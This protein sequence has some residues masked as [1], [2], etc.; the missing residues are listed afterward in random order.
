MELPVSVLTKNQVQVTCKALPT[1][2]TRSCD[3]AGVIVT[4]R[5]DDRCGNGHNTFSITTDWLN[6]R[7]WDTWITVGTMPKNPIMCGAAHDELVEVFPEYADLIKWHLCSSDGPMYYVA[8]TTYFASE[9][10]DYDYILWLEKDEELGIDGSKLLSAVY[11]SAK[12]AEAMDKFDKLCTTLTESKIKFRVER[13]PNSLNKPSNLESA[14]NAA[15]WPEATLE[16]LQDKE[17]L[18]ARLPSLMA[19]FKATM[20]GLGFIY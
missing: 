15:I 3:P 6:Q 2:P 19:E 20:E 17:Q 7:Q 4:M 9:V 5:F 11:G 18:E 10:D 1:K 8:N 13:R 12:N 16:Q 14:R